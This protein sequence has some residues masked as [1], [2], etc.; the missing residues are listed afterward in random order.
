MIGKKQKQPTLSFKHVLVLPFIDAFKVRGENV[1]V[2]NPLSGNSVVTGFVE[3]NVLG[4]MNVELTKA[5]RRGFMDKSVTITAE[6]EFAPG[7]FE[8]ELGEAVSRMQKAAGKAGADVVMAGILYDYRERVGRDYGV[9]TPAR[10]S[11]ELNLVNV[12]TGRLVW[13]AH[14]KEKQQ[15]LNKNVFQLSTFLRRKGRWVTAKQMA[16]DAMN[17]MMDDLLKKYD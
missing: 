16:A 3:H 13:Q 1:E 5:L 15:S 12:E 10:I 2:R 11:F 8:K 6:K 14:Y 9:E 17:Q 4:T 7:L